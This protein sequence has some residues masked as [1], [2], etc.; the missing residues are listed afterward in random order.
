M[1][2]YIASTLTD[3]ERLIHTA[4]F[5]WIYTVTSFFYVISLGSWG[6]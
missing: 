2:K 3:G 1:T 5:H 6:F 4:E